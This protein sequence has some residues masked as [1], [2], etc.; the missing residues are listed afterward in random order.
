MRSNIKWTRI[1][2]KEKLKMG[3]DNL[4]LMMLHNMLA[5]INFWVF[6]AQMIINNFLRAIRLNVHKNL[7]FK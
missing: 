5:H 1:N 4:N 2:F 7:I 6:K 3:Q